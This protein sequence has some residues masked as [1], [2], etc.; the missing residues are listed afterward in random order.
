MT[1]GRV[2]NLRQDR[3]GRGDAEDSRSRDTDEYSR[4]LGDDWEPMGDGTYRFVG[5]QKSV[6]AG[7]WADRPLAASDDSPAR[8][9]NDP[10]SSEHAEGGKRRRWRKH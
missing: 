2:I 1:V 10:E 5:K 3:R 4:I 7:P 8:S 6:P 9:E